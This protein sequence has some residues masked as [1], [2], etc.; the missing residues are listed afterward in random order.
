M[1][2]QC[3]LALLDI[4]LKNRRLDCFKLLLEAGADP[5]HHREVT[6]H[7][8]HSSAVF[9]SCFTKEYG[10]EYLDALL[11]CERMLTPRVSSTLHSR[12]TLPLEES[13]YSGCISR[14]STHSWQQPLSSRRTK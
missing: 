4:A 2:F 6:R 3:N 7:G 1:I 14:K 13:S 12:H 11:E 10:S 9:E 5:E 8:L